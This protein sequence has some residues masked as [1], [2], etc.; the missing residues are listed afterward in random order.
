VTFDDSN[1]PGC[2]IANL[3]AIG[4]GPATAI[5]TAKSSPKHRSAFAFIVHVSV[6]AFRV[7]A[8]LPLHRRKRVQPNLQ[9]IN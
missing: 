2:V 4:T 3:I 1:Y 9:G 8:A 7:V 5:D 6:G